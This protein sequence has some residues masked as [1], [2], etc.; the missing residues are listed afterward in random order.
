MQTDLPLSGVKVLDL[1]RVLAGPLSTMVLADLGAD[2]IK[3]EHPQRGD[4]TRDWGMP[5]APGETTYFYGFNRNKRSIA[6]DIGT[7]EGAATIRQ[8]ATQCDVVVE[9]FKSGGMERFGLGYEDL[10]ALN[11]KIVYC[12]IAGYDRAGPE[13]AR[14]GYDLVIQGESGLMG[15]NGEAGRPPLK[16][17]VAAVD[18]F[19]GMYAAQAVLA[20]LFKTRSTGKGCRIDLALYDC[21]VMISSYY[22]LEALLLGDDPPRYG[23]EH[24]SIV[25][26]GVFQ[27]ADGPL[28][29]A[30]GNNRQYQN[31]C[32][33]VL[34]RPDL[35]HDAR[36][37]TNLKRAQNREALS[38]LLHA[39]LL[40]HPRQALLDKLTAAGIPNGQVL[41]LHEALVGSRTQAAGLLNKLPHPS[42]GE[43]SVLS[44]PW[45][46]DGHRL[47]VRRPP[48][49]G[50]HSEEITAALKAGSL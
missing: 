20:A 21:G 1:S 38:A 9:N 48:R 39:E 46:F 41:G 4:D 11:P 7:A 26:Y 50:E 32:I 35:A 47:P 30:V 31:F 33:D 27:S 43:V 25:P 19:T 8:L 16:F 10:K 36:F 13:A 6:V 14:P 45:R 24:P 29:I 17:G 22:G 40:R 15:I 37:E 18:L 5:L 23:N 49:L 28:V 2:V 44:S 3:V 34:G 12:A 42:A